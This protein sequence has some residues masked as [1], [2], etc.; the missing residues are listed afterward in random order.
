MS[1]GNTWGLS[2]AALVGGYSIQ[3][4]AFGDS[5]LLGWKEAI[6]FH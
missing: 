3:G 5:G 6:Q 2:V 4:E 1:L